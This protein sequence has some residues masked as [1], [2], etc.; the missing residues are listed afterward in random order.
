MSDMK[1]PGG[2]VLSRR[3]KVLLALSGLLPAHFIVWAMVR[4]EALR[5]ARAQ[6]AISVWGLEPGLGIVAMFW[7]GLVALIAAIVSSA[8]D[9]RRIRAN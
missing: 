3:S 4:G 2:G 7:S 8:V 9:I 1:K 6:G 5:E